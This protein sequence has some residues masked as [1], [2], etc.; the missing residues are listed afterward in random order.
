MGSEKI[1]NVGGGQKL[2]SGWYIWEG[3]MSEEECEY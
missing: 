3:R 2:K 1:R